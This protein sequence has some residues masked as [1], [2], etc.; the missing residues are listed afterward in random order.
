MNIKKLSFILILLVCS[1]IIF[2]HFSQLRN[3]ASYPQSSYNLELKPEFAEAFMSGIY[4]D[5]WVKDQV[6]VRCKTPQNFRK[7]TL[8]LEV[9]AMTTNNP[10]TQNNN[11]VSNITI[12]STF[13]Q[14]VNQFSL[15]PGRHSLVISLKEQ[16]P[17]D[18]LGFFLL[19]FSGGVK[20]PPGTRLLRAR[21]MSFNLV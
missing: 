20:S 16:I 12:Y 5:L 1:F 15:T 6:K 8:T 7:V 3:A 9:P 21:L 14:E 2:S 17:P 19:R 10:R 11:I 4:L 13:N 18:R